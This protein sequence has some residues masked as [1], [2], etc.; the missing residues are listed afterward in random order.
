MQ[1][2]ELTVNKKGM[3]VSKKDAPKRTDRKV[4]QRVQRQEIC[5]GEFEKIQCERTPVKP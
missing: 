5:R 3:D 1:D 2:W 4:I